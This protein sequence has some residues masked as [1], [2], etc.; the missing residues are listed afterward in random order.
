[1]KK[2]LVLLFGLAALGYAQLFPA[3]NQPIVGS[4]L[5]TATEAL[6][7]VLYV[8]TGASTSNVCPT[9]GASGSGGSNT[10]IC[11]TKDN[12][13]W[14]SITARIDGTLTITSPLYPKCAP[15]VRTTFCN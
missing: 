1:M 4:T 12:I 5:P 15:P 9:A 14:N 11:F 2:L 8:W 13:N 6:P 3:P 10:A 7:N